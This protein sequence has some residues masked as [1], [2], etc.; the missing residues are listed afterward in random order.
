MKTS[1]LTIPAICILPIPET[2]VATYAYD[3]AYLAINVFPTE[4][5]SKLQ[6]LLGDICINEQVTYSC[7]YSKRITFTLRKIP[8]AELVKY[9]GFNLD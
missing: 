1:R 4:A 2:T 8:D 3:I 6:H 9:L 5:S 7:W